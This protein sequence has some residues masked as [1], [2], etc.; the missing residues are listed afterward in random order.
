MPVMRELLGDVL[1]GQLQTYCH[2]E[3][4]YY[5]IYN[6]LQLNY[7]GYKKSAAPSIAAAFVWS[8][9]L[10]W[11]P[12]A[13]DFDYSPLITN[14][15]PIW[16]F[17]LIGYQRIT[18]K[19]NSIFQ[20]MPYNIW[21]DDLVPVLE[22]KSE[23]I[24]LM[25]ALLKINDNSLLRYLH[26]H[27]IGG[28]AITGHREFHVKDSNWSFP[29]M[30]EFLETTEWLMSTFGSEH[31]VIEAI[32]TA[33]MLAG[34]ARSVSGKMKG[35]ST[36]NIDVAESFIDYAF[37]GIP[38]P[39]GFYANLGLVVGGNMLASLD[40]ILDDPSVF[41][42]SA[43]CSDG[44]WERVDDTVRSGLSQPER[45]VYMNASMGDSIS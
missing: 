18:F 14:Y 39:S 12:N 45:I 17:A 9:D 1:C 23:L 37:D 8:H 33:S 26:D 44:F 15:A 30:S 40:R 43:W 7:I 4:H 21:G 41:F 25:L 38:K 3:D 20:L 24:P 36:P 42:N 35:V 19:A 27:K 32:E 10:S 6:G 29:T 16:D 31:D 34:V 28:Q 22:Q 5:P 2:D 11:G 13:H